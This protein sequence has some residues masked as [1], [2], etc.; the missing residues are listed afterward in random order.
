MYAFHSYVP[1]VRNYTNQLYFSHDLPLKVRGA[2]YTSVCIIL[3][4]LQ[5]FSAVFALCSY[6]FILCVCSVWCLMLKLHCMPVWGR[7]L[8]SLLLTWAL[9]LFIKWMSS[10]VPMVC[11]F[12][13]SLYCR[14]VVDV[15][16]RICVIPK[17]NQW[18]MVYPGSVYWAAGKLASAWD[19]ADADENV[20]SHRI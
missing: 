16:R 12:P 7:Y 14:E 6:V 15:C 9:T 5:Y 13:G 10:Y 1:R 20:P 11:I 17:P 18:V 4:F 19:D 8:L 3:E 2:Y